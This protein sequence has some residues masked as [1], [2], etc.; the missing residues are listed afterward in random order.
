MAASFWTL[1][2]ALLICRHFICIQK[3]TQHGWIN[4]PSG[5]G[6]LSALFL[7]CT[8][9]CKYVFLKFQLLLFPSAFLHFS[10]VTLK[11]QDHLFPQPLTHTHTHRDTHT[12]IFLL[13]VSWKSSHKPRPVNPLPGFAIH[14][15]FLAD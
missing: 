4:Q 2:K 9:V 6:N 15:G 3:G 14:L 12:Q 13:L 10:A 5:P 11:R 8:K 7:N 1:T